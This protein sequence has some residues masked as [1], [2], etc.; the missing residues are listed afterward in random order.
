MTSSRKVVA[1][2]ALVLTV[3]GVG[4]VASRSGKVYTRSQARE[5]HEV[6]QATVVHVAPVQIEGTKSGVGTVAGGVIGGV[7]GSTIGGG[8]GRKLATVAGAVIGAAAGAAAEE[9]VTKADAYEITVKFDDGRTVA[10]VQEA[11]EY[12]AEGERVSILTSYDGT[13]R[14]RKA[15]Q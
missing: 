4:C 5:T 3:G 1:C 10:I 9:G 12:F 6:H 14:V 8:S 2:L 13:T 7:V 11:D 15:N